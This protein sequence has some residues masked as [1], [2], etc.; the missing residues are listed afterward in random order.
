MT[1]D[2]S[3]KQSFL[4]IQL[5]CKTALHYIH[6]GDYQKARKLLADIDMACFA[7][8]NE[9]DNWQDMQYALKDHSLDT[10]IP[11]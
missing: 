5:N 10:D 2:D 6:Y 9:I 4:A 1:L 8:S 7:A 3:L 11:W